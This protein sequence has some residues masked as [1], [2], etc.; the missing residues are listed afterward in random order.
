MQYLLRTIPTFQLQFQINKGA[1]PVKMFIEFLCSL[2]LSYF[3]PFL[4]LTWKTTSLITPCGSVWP[5]NY[6]KRSNQMIATVQA[7]LLFFFTNEVHCL[8]CIHTSNL[9]LQ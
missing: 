3:I 1:H 4:Q 7:L 2:I 5:Q 9:G 8:Y 6:S